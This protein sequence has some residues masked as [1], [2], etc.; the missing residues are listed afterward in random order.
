MLEFLGLE[1]APEM[2]D[3]VERSEQTVVRTPSYHQVVKPVYSDS[4]ERW[5]V[6]EQAFAE[7][8]DTLAPFI[9]KFGYRGFSNG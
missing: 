1:W 7:V 5:R 3:Y 8:R 4:I 6:H 2:L 9:E